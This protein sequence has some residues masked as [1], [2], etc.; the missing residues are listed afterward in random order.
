MFTSPCSV[1]RSDF[2]YKLENFEIHLYEEKFCHY[3]ALHCPQGHTFRR[4]SSMAWL[5]AAQ[6]QLGGRRLNIILHGNAP[7]DLQAAARAAWNEQ[8]LFV[9]LDRALNRFGETGLIY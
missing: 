8:S 1:C 3:I 7:S 4:F 5:E 6:K 2:N 9:E